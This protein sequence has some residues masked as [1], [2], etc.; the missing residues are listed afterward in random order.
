V[1]TREAWEQHGALA[2]IWTD[3]V[4]VMNGEASHAFAGVSALG[5]ELDL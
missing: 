1:T 5:V 2:P 3:L 4:N